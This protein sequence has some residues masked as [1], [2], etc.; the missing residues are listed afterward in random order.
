M[1]LAVH[2]A[3][4]KIKRT[5]LTESLVAIYQDSQAIQIHSISVRSDRANLFEEAT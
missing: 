5:E 2:H 1:F 3:A 4:L